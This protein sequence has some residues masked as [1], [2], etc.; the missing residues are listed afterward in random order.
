MKTQAKSHMPC[1]KGPGSTGRL[2][3]Q[4]ESRQLHDPFT[5]EEHLRVQVEIEERAHQFWF[6]K[7]CTSNN[8]L[9]DWLKAENEVLAEFARTRMQSCPTRQAKGET[10]TTTRRT[11]ALTPVESKLT[12]KPIKKSIY[13]LPYGL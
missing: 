4:V 12:S 9:Y 5:I 11:S 13:A 8:A 10:Q 1:K 2:H 6:A 3:L 7:G